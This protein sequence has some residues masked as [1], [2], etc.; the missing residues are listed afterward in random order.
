MTAA[1][2]AVVL[3]FLFIT[4]AALGGLRIADRIQLVAPP[5]VS[6]V[7]GVFLIGTLVRGGLLAPERLMSARR[8]A[9]ENLN[10]LVVLLA[11]FGGS[12]QVFTLVTPDSGLLHA[13]FSIALF[14]QL[15]TTLAGIRE[16]RALLRSLAILLGSAFVLRF[17]VLDTLYAP[18]GSWGQRVLMAILEGASLG[19]IVY[20]PTGTLTGY[21][22][23]AALGLYLTGLILLPRAAPTSR[24]GGQLE[25]RSQELMAVLLLLALA[26]SAAA[27]SGR[28]AA[29]EPQS[30]SARA[31]M[32]DDALARAHVW[33]PPAIPI[34]EFDF[35][36]NPP[37]GFGTA[38]DVDCEFSVQKLT[39]RTRKFHCRVPD[40]RIVKVKYG[41]AN[42][43]LQAEVAGTRLL[44]A[45]GFAADDMFVVHTVR[46]AGCP[47]F[48]FEALLCHE[49]V[50]IEPLCFYGASDPRRVRVIAPA[51][52][53]RRLPGT[54]IEAT[55]DQ[56]WSWFELDRIDPARGG[57]TRAEVDA[58]RLLAVVLA[59]WDNKGPNQRLVCPEGMQLPDGGCREPVAMIQDVGATFGPQRVDLQNWRTVPV[60]R[61]SRT[62][63][64][65]MKSLPFGGAT[66]EDR[67][68]SE[69]GRQMLAS[70]LD[71]LTDKQLVDLFTAARFVDY[72]AIGAE[73]RDARAWVRAFREKITAVKEG[74]PCE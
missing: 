73:A 36:A 59:H 17:L 34:S 11:L 25:V 74:G 33:H 1:R 3:P 60:W 49:A 70:L 12:A 29:A 14:V 71:Q 56:G 7:L 66:F 64:V 72:D 16:P 57:S 39:G 30:D 38:D 47:S 62:C 23:F 8:T 67:N 26:G 52:I 32:R 53:E 46:C 44:H 5:L 42:G 24:G 37:G 69:P 4:V 43:E 51:V 45:L 9:L 41:A 68:I 31:R 19:S 35:S 55:E 2:E 58:F 21:V 54:V 6:L 13:V 27:C 50:G 22:A 48:P 20:E 18:H 63:A 15:A 61:D 65:S 10:G 40:G 28:D